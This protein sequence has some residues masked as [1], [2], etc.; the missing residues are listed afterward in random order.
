MANLESLRCRCETAYCL[1]EFSNDV[2]RV[3]DRPF[4][5]QRDQFRMARAGIAVLKAK[6]MFASAADIRY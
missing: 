4:V 2:C 6:S 1:K 3:G 5:R